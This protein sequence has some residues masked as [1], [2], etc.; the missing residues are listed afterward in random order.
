MTPMHLTSLKTVL[1]LFIAIIALQLCI[2]LGDRLLTNHRASIDERIRS[3]SEIEQLFLTTLAKELQA[4]SHQPNIHIIN[5]DFAKQKLLIEKSGLPID[6]TPLEERIALN[7]RQLEVIKEKGELHRE[8]ASLMSTLS[9]SVGYIHQHHLVHFKNM[10]STG[11]VTEDYYS[12]TNFARSASIEDTELEKIEA[13]IEIQN[14]LLLVFQIFSTFHYTAIADNTTATFSSTLDRFQ[15]SVNVFENLSL[16]AQDGLLVE[17]LILNGSTFKKS[18]KQF[19]TFQQ[20]LESIQSKFISNQNRFLRGL[21][22]VKAQTNTELD[23]VAT[24]FKNARFISLLFNISMFLAV[25]FYGHRIIQALKKTV[26][27][28]K[29]I[30]NNFTYRILSGNSDFHEFSTIFTTLNLM[31]STVNQKV[32][33]LETTQNQ[34]EERVKLRTKELFDSN[35][36]LKTEI[37]TKIQHENERRTLEEQLSRAQKM[38]ALGTLAGGVAHDLNNILTGLV[39][40]PELIL[41]DLPENHK[42]R[43]PIQTIHN[44][45]KKAAIIVQDLL[46]MARRGVATQEPVDL[47]I[48]IGQHLTSPE[49]KNLLELNPDVKIEYNLSTSGEL[50]Q[51]S[52]THLQ[53]TLMNLITNAVESI[54]LEGL[55]TIQTSSCY[56][57]KP[58]GNYNKVEEG[59]YILLTIRD[60]GIGIAEEDLTKIFEPFFTTKSLGRSG[61][62]LGMAVVWG[63]IKDHGGY[64]DVTSKKTKGTTFELYFPR[65]RSSKEFIVEKS[66]MQR[67]EGDG[68]SILVIDDIKEQREIATLI[69]T[70][71]GYHVESVSSGEGAINVVKNR[72]VD[73]LLLDMIMLPG[74]DGL[75]TYRQI[76]KIAPKQKAIIVSGF[77]E[78]T[79]VTEAQKL[80]TGAFVKKPYSFEEL[81]IA[82]QKE[83]KK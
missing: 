69:L 28:T 50:M 31:A 39:S 81:A 74:I 25:I 73:L 30:Q 64:I 8:I 4:I 76:I 54:T 17:E 33:E 15:K 53:K 45:G 66:V 44:S 26:S 43:G 38:E 10:L 3:I 48:I 9:A 24:N 60:N 71:L 65:L 79:K 46:T 55:I 13:I 82:V 18:Y 12:D 47:N 27:E 59:E 57:D 80:G 40:Y 23:T 1:I 77:S 36:K 68:E 11:A 51:G 22:D 20:E 61:S 62:G 2:A 32:D 72:Q 37:A 41:L 56:V 29:K 21:E 19:V 58:F 42:L 75:E 70:K 7:N 63:T 49:Y 14:T 83:L 78:N 35:V 16:D 67:V 52:K 5:Q 34:L 6:T